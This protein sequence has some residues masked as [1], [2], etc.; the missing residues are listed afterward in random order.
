MCSPTRLDSD[1]TRQQIRSVTSSQEIIPLSQLAKSRKLAR[2]RR[3]RSLHACALW[4]EPAGQ[5]LVPLTTSTINHNQKPPALLPTRLHLRAIETSSLW[6][7][8]PLLMISD[9]SNGTANMESTAAVGGTDQ[10]LPTVSPPLSVG[11]FCI[12]Q[13]SRCI[14]QRPPFDEKMAKMHGLTQ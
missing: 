8:P 3:L 14:V 5:P 13:R 4:A 10:E 12:T 9:T 6:A 2:S 1:C 11:L 7:S